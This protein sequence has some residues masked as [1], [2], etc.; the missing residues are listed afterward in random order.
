[1]GGGVVGLTT[2]LRLLQEI[3]GCCV[4]VYAEA[5]GTDLVSAGAAG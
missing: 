4:Q 3:P 5:W 1:V 2:A